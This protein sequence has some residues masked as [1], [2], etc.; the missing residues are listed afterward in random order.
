MSNNSRSH[1]KKNLWEKTCSLYT[2][3]SKA[4]K[5]LV[6]E[7]LSCVRDLCYLYIRH[8]PY[9]A[10]DS[11]M[12][13]FIL[14]I[15]SQWKTIGAFLNNKC[16]IH[17]AHCYSAGL[18]NL[19][20]ADQRAARHEVLMWPASRSIISWLK[21]I[22]VIINVRQ[23]F[24][25]ELYSNHVNCTSTT[26]TIAKHSKLDESTILPFSWCTS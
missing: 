10:C 26:N 2:R 19:R 6:K 13:N 16:I 7:N 9:S 11:S 14:K 22:N 5:E 23:R 4:I 20:P 8:Y 25:D 24:G 15:S 1:F 3:A 21:L 18:S 12:L 17:P